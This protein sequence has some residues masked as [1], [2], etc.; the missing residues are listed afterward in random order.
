MP[1]S[2]APTSV[3]VT[4]P[5][6]VETP[7]VERA[8][9]SLAKYT[10]TPP[11]YLIDRGHFD[12][13]WKFEPNVQ[14]LPQYSDYA[15]KE[16]GAYPPQAQELVST[17]SSILLKKLG[18]YDY[19]VD[20]AWKPID[21][22]PPPLPEGEYGLRIAISEPRFKKDKEEILKALS[23]GCNIPQKAI[24]ITFPPEGGQEEK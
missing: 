9:R 1:K 11:T 24:S 4:S 16:F 23:E 10:D 8:P 14:E 18:S 12:K 17:A 20:L 3:S 7:W 22:T 19:F 5:P 13:L 6:A 15:S 21:K 2:P